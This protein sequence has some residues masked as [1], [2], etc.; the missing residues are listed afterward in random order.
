[1]QQFAQALGM[2]RIVR[3]RAV[4][5]CRFIMVWRKPVADSGCGVDH[6]APARDKL[7][8]RWTTDNDQFYLMPVV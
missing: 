7:L 5:S 2:A 3:P 8:N 4:V 6:A 1:V